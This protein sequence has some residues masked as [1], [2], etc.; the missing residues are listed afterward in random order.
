MQ[1]ESWYDNEAVR[2]L[3][4]GH[5]GDQVCAHRLSGTI[6]NLVDE[7]EH[8]D[9][10][11]KALYYG[12]DM[13]AEVEVP[14]AGFTQ[15]EMNL[16]HGGIGAV[17]EAIELLDAIWDYLHADEKG[18]ALIEQNIFEELGDG[19]WYP[20]HVRRFFGWTQ[21]EIQEGNIRKLRS[22]FPKKFTESHALNRNIGAEYAAM[23]GEAGA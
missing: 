7:G 18:R 8:L 16:L 15:E 2:T 10:I 12:K 11:K 4:D 21:R 22:R 9:R 23:R 19:E 20:V 3:A 1:D 6:E 5:Y 13:M 14:V 17:T